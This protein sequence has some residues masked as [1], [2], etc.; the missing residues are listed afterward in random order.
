MK[1]IYE[2]QG[3]LLFECMIAMFIIVSSLLFLMSTMIF[4]FKET[5][6][7]QTELEMAT[8]LYEMAAFKQNKLKDE[9]LIR[10]K[11][12]DHDFFI[13]EWN[14]DRVR[15]ECEDISLEIQRK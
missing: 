2:N 10:K 3:Y 9:T 7:K 14:T 13:K 15:I 8:Q 1:K 4:F 6:L 12:T 11:A 5:N